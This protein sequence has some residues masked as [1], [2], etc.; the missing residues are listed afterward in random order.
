[1]SSKSKHAQG[2]VKAIGLDQEL[3]KAKRP[4]LKVDS[5]NLTGLSLDQFS[6]NGFM[7]IRLNYGWIIA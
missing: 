5:G 3:V 1:M 2:L 6:H 7:V 4:G